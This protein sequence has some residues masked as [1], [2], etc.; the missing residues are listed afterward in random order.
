MTRGTCLRDIRGRVVDLTRF[1]ILDLEL[2]PSRAVWYRV[3]SDLR[4][5][6]WEGIGLRD[7]DA[8]RDFPPPPPLDPSRLA[9]MLLARGGPFEREGKKKKKL[10]LSVRGCS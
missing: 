2:A 6:A 4:F 1:I 10:K 3:A 5:R 7:R 9:L 8:T